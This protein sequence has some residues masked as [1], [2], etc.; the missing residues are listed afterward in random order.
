M[1]KGINPQ[2][3]G[4]VVV[5]RGINIIYSVSFYFCP[6]VLQAYYFY[7]AAA[8]SCNGKTA[9]SPLNFI[10]SGKLFFV[11]HLLISKGFLRRG[12]STKHIHT[13]VRKSNDSSKFADRVVRGSLEEMLLFDNAGKCIN[14]MK[15]VSNKM[16]LK[17]AYIKIKSDLSKSSGVDKATSDVISEE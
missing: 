1:P 9:G 8:F 3:I 11:G 7:A 6:A 5:G 14:A 13:K 16:I 15:L 4:S 17:N 2:G 12:D 10:K